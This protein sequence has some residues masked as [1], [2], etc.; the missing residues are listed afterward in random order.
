MEQTAREELF[1]EQQNFYAESQRLTMLRDQFARRFE[2]TRN[3]GLL[4]RIAG[5]DQQLNELGVLN[6]Q[7]VERNK[8]N[9]LLGLTR[10]IA[11]E[12]TTLDPPSQSS[13][14]PPT[15]SQLAT[16]PGS[17]R[18]TLPEYTDILNGR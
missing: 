14:R 1:V 3:P 6:A 11:G 13:F 2:E 9:P 10:R 16:A 7:R 18:M 4:Q 5:I 12:A 15:R 17:S 8:R